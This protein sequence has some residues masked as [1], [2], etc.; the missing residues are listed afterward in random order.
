M[1]TCVLFLVSCVLA[2]AAA[3]A[4]PVYYRDASGR[5]TGTAMQNGGRIVYRDG[6]G[7]LTGSAVQQGGRVVYRDAS[8]R[9]AGTAVQNG[10]RTVY[11][12]GQGRMTGTTVNQAIRPC[13]A[14]RRAGCRA[15]QTSRAGGSSTV[16]VR[17]VTP[18]PPECPR[19]FPPT[20]MPTA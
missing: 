10:N 16:T 5:L 8:G 15:G 17:A 2:F 9:L 19:E 12:D 13:F 18:A 7:R 6:Q 1:K 20:G 14:M 11:R 3:A 4:P